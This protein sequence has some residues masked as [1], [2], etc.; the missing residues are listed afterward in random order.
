MTVNPLIRTEMA[1]LRFITVSTVF[2]S[3]ISS[4]LSGM[5]SISWPSLFFRVLLPI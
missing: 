5:L 1:V 2:K 3:K 4:V